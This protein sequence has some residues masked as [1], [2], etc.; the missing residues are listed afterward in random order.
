MQAFLNLY[1]ANMM[2]KRKYSKMK[3][4]PKFCQKKQLLQAIQV[5]GCLKPYNQIIRICVEL[6]SLYV[7]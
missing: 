7:Y 6:K 1:Y 3:V 5:V 2:F 4:N